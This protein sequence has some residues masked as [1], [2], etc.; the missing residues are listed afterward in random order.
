VARARV[1]LTIRNAGLTRAMALDANGDAAAPA[2]LVRQTDKG[3]L[4]F[5]EDALYVVLQ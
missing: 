2:K 4:S 3:V 1:T 5:P